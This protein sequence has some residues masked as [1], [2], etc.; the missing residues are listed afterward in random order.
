MPRFRITTSD[1]SSP[2]ELVE[3]SLLFF[4]VELSLGKDGIDRGFDLRDVLY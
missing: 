2:K 3:P 4:V 1:P